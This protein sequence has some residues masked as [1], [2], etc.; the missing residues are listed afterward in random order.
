MRNKIELTV[1]AMIAETVK[2]SRELSHPPKRELRSSALSH[3][4]QI[5]FMIPWIERKPEDEH[6]TKDFYCG[7]GTAVHSSLQKWM[8]F[9][10]HLYGK[11]KCPECCKIV[12][13]GFGPVI[14]YNTRCNFLCTYEEYD[15]SWKGLTGHCDGI[16]IIDNKCY[17]LEFKTISLEG[18]RR[19]IKTNEPDEFH[20]NQVN[21]YVLMGQKLA[22]PYPLVGAVI[23]Y[24]ARDNPK[25]HAAFL[26][27][28]VNFR[29]V[30]EALRQYKQAGQMVAS[31][32][33][34]DVVRRCKNLGDAP[35]CAYKSMCFR[36]NVEEHLAKYWEL[37]RG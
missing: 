18:L 27:E 30:Q 25:K 32:N 22:L 10:S 29:D 37:Y 24:I 33:F 20:S 1:E 14:H 16:I 13:E 2:A 5:A 7:I 6:F 23:V 4:C 9:K 26:K 34:K 8:G 36:G 31:G 21:M 35:F 19:H 15:L 3:F 28:G 17:I 12:K 11:W